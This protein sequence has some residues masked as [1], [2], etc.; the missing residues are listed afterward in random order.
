MAIY[1]VLFEK[2]YTSLIL[3]TIGLFSGL[4]MDDDI[5]DTCHNYALPKE[6]PK[7]IEITLHTT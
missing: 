3:L 7:N 6:D 1:T 5:D 2:S 4:L